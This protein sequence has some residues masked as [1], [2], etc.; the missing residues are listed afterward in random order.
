MSDNEQSQ[1]V[2]Q[3]IHG[4]GYAKLESLMSADEAFAIRCRVL[5]E[6]Q[7]QQE[8]NAETQ[9][10][11][12]VISVNQLLRLGSEFEALVTNPR[13]LAI[14]YE[15]LGTDATLGDMA[16]KVLMP[17]CEPGG[18]HVDYPY[19]AMDRGL[20]VAPAMML[21]VIWMME[22]F[23]Q[24]NGGTWIAPTSQK[25]TE[26]LHQN[27]FRANTIQAL[28]SAGDAILSHGMLWHQTAENHSSQPRVAILINY[29]QIAVRPMREVKPFDDEFKAQAS[30]ELSA[31]LGFDLSTALISRALSSRVK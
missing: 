10:D 6:M 18:L 26:P 27:P 30:A 24:E 11:S 28:G 7:L 3:L 14:V 20:P 5:A 31:L 21:Q 4:D 1:V 12:G 23:T 29:T 8:Q 9:V 22:P 13:L 19:W 16:A 2:D 15:L 25:W 17:G